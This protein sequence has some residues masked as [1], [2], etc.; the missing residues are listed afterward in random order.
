MK[1][2]PVTILNRHGARALTKMTETPLNVQTTKEWAYFILVTKHG[3][4]PERAKKL[5]DV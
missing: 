4:P 2:H 3:V 5:L 1:L